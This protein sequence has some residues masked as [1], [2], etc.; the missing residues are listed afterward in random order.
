M[1]LLSGLDHGQTVAAS[2]DEQ[3]AL[4]G[5]GLVRSLSKS[6]ADELRS[7]VDNLNALSS[8]IKALGRALHGDP[9]AVAFTGIPSDEAGLRRELQAS[10]LQLEDAS[11]R[12]AEAD[13][14]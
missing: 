4:E 6:E 7:L 12:K 14:L 2:A 8:R 10:V 11:R 1:E 13:A 9:S 5:E 3:A